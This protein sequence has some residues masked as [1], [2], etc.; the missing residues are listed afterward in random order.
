M[1][2]QKLLILIAMGV[3]SLVIFA[4][5]ERIRRKQGEGNEVSRKM[6][7]MIHGSVISV[8][9]FLFGYWLVYAIEVL[10]LLSVSEAY[11]LKIFRWLWRVGRKSWGEYAYPVGVIAAAF[12]AHS[13]WIFLTGVLILTFADAMAALVGKKYG[14]KKFQYKVFHQTKS[15]PGSLAFIIT[16]F[17]ILGITIM[18]SPE[19]FSLAS[20]GMVGAV[21]T[22]LMFVENAGV[23]GLD[24]FLLP[25]VSVLLLNAL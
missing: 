18:F 8:I 11:K 9:P 5:G 3:V 24:N 25:V 21:A 7:H 12:L 6:V 17:V 19:Q 4:V 2:I 22:I 23:Y 16:A 13:K 1:V 15:V 14:H 20:W 10:F